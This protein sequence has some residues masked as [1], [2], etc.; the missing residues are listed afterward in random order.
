MCVGD[1]QLSLTSWGTTAYRAG[2]R[3]VW[4]EAV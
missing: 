2:E 1:D 3:L 4:V